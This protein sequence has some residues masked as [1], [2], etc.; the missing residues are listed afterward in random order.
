MRLGVRL[1]VAVLTAALALLVPGVPA[2]AHNTLRSASPARDATLTSAPVEVTL[3]FM[4]ELDPAFATVVLTGADRRRIATGDPVVGG[5]R[6]TVQVT[7]AV[8]NGTYTVAYRVV[9]VD[10]HPLQGS[11]PFTVAD[12]TAGGDAGAATVESHDGP[13]VGLL[14]AGGALV[15]LA[16]AAAGLGWRRRRA[17]R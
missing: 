10:G 3:E 17:G 1:G 7:G 11:Y 2:Q 9:S 15:A 6:S 4:D 14:V 16:V 12:P 5:A 13:G 8:A